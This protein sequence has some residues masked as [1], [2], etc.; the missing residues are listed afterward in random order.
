MNYVGIDIIEI[1]RIKRAIGRWGSAFLGRIYTP[2]ELA[3]FQA[4]PASLA[5]RFAGKEAVIK[6]LGIKNSPYRDIEILNDK[7]GRPTLRLYGRALK[8]SR[9]LGVELKVSL[10][11]SRAY[12]VACASGT[13]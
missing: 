7:Y 3:L 5:A 8:T 4:K 10:S 11:H 1:G 2:D 12:A 6:A 9:Q 13:D